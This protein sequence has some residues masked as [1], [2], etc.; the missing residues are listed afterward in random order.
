MARQKLDQMLVRFP[1]GM[2]DELKRVAQA[3]RRSA[4]AQ[5]ITILE[6]GLAAEKAASN[7]SA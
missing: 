6:S 7:H 2:R 1:E 3:H 4:N 5:L